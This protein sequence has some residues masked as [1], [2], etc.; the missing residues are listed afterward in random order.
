MAANRPVGWVAAASRCQ[1]H[2]TRAITQPSQRTKCTKPGDAVTFLAPDAPF[3]RLPLSL[4]IHGFPG[5]SAS[6]SDRLRRS[7]ARVAD[8]IQ[9]LVLLPSETWFGVVGIRSKAVSADQHAGDE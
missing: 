3:P 8:A 7:R 4:W 6:D 9:R 2:E 1:S 5:I